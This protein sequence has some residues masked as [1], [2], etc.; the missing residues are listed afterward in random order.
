MFLKRLVLL[1]ILSILS[2]MALTVAGLLYVEHVNMTD[3]VYTNYGFPYWWLTHVGVTLAG[4]TDTWWFEKSN[5]V[6]DMILF[7]L[8]SLGFWFLILLSKERMT[9]T[10]TKSKKQLSQFDASIHG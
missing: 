10:I 3:S 8:L 1:L 9:H 7:F 4:P 5:L 2:S 6:K